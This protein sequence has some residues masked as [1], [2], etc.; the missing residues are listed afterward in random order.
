MNSQ[1]SAIASKLMVLEDE[2]CARFCVAA[3]ARRGADI[4]SVHDVGKRAHVDHI[5]SSDDSN[6]FSDSWLLSHLKHNV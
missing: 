2:E 3:A 4:I 5:R 1:P 6:P